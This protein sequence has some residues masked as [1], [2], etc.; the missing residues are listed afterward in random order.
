MESET[1]YILHIWHGRRKRNDLAPY[2]GEGDGAA[3]LSDFQH[4]WMFS[5]AMRTTRPAL[6][7]LRLPALRVEFFDTSTFY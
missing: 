2:D 3:G 1:V 5:F 4:A 6:T 7:D